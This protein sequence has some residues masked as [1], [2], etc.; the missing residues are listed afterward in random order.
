MIKKILL[1]CLYMPLS[2]R[3]YHFFRG[4]IIHVPKGDSQVKIAIFTD[5]YFPQ[6][7]GVANSLKR[8]TDHLEKRQ[9]QYQIFAPEVEDTP[10]YPNINQFFSI[11]VFLYP[12]CRTALAN[13]KRIKAK[14]QEFNPDI[15]HIATPYMMGLYGLFCAKKLHIPVVSSY[16]THFDQYLEYYR[17]S[18]LLPVLHKYLKWFHESTERTF[19]PSKETKSK[20]AEL[21]FHSLSI[22][23]RGVDCSQFHPIAV[24][25]PIRE[26]YNI[27]EEY[28]LLY[29]G[30]FAPEKDL[31]TLSA[32]MDSLPESWNNRVHWLL[33]G[34]GPCLPEWKR[35][36]AERKNMTLTGYLK[37]AELSQVYASADLFVFPSKTETFGNVVLES[38]A[39]GTPAI[40]SN[41]GGV[42]EMVEDGVTGRICPAKSTEH[43]TAAIIEL[44]NQTMMRNMFGTAA[45][46]YA[47]SQSWE[48]ILDG[49]IGEYE[50]VI[51]N[52]RE[53]QRIYA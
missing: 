4:I 23:G 13:P 18:W 5:T 31:A 3:C 47:L 21:G 53:D 37:G 26:K 36:A 38:L 46:K 14:V 39:S 44:L 6:V 24:N 43:F 30:R 1:Q 20:L 27:Q 48:S 10:A 34:D 7:N 51:M 28:I 32:I 41:S 33:A 2:N 52:S 35:K 29:V 8:L 25:Q 19:V 16:H 12:E 50:E 15:I 22:W 45:R 49:L 17:A 9:I 40:V 42:K 11:P